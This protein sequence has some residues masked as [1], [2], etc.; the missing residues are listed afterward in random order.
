MS[1]KQQTIIYLCSNKPQL[2]FINQYFYDVESKMIYHASEYSNIL[3]YFGSHQKC[4]YKTECD[5]PSFTEI[6]YYKRN[7]TTDFLQ[8]IIL[9]KILDNL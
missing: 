8:N 2:G 7:M 4:K 1:T 6:L 5:I 3:M 9:S